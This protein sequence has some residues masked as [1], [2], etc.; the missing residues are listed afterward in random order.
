[1]P[2]SYT[3][4]HDSDVFRSSPTYPFLTL[5]SAALDKCFP[6]LLSYLPIK[7]E[8][9]EYLS[10]FH[11]RVYQVPAEITNSKIEHFLSNARKNSKVY[12]TT[13]ALLFRLIAL[14]AQ[15]S[16]WDRGGGRWD[17]KVIKVKTQKGNVYS[18]CIK[19][20]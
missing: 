2:L 6:Q 17:A 5:F 4:P 12:P 1:L 13:L 16:A 20:S 15:H 19:V 10:A 14:G 7:E 11:R 8:L 3:I 18:K 9:I